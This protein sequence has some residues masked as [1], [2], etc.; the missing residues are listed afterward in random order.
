MN[1]TFWLNVLTPHLTPLVRSLA[2]LPNQAVTV[3][4]QGEPATVR[5]EIEWNLQDCTPAD[6]LQ[7]PTDEEVVRIL[8]QIQP[9]R[10][11]VHL[12][13]G[14]TNVPFNQRILPRLVERGALVGLITESADPRGILGAARRLKY[15]LDSRLMNRKTGFILAMGQLGVQWFI[16]AGYNIAT[17]Y[18]F[19]YVPER[20]Q[21][22]ME[23]RKGR[24]GSE[25]F[26]I[27][28]L[29]QIIPRKDG[30]T[31]IRALAGI[32]KANWQVSFVGNGPDL[33]RWKKVASDSGVA[34]RMC[35]QPAVDYRRVGELLAQA[36]ILLL[37]SRWDG[38]GAVVNEAL[39]C[40]VPVVCSDKC[41]AADLLREPWRGQI[42]KTGSAEDLR[43]VLN[44]WI[45]RGP[46]STETT[47]RIR[48]WSS[49]IEA[50]QV[51]LYLMR[52]VEHVQNGGLPPSP[53]WY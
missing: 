53:P 52:V 27:L 11:S 28:Y 16:S 45:E 7:C 21:L 33:K 40:G 46:R 43:R 13:N 2:R 8:G 23:G 50:P 20:P 19:M 1:W 37:P 10:L 47:A 49:A 35:F 39:M 29:G 22:A 32:S 48:K 12:L 30:I 3:V 44:E 5:K 42:F 14:I 25:A 17:V 38:W 31:A 26:S 18:P 15:S 36:D 4:A 51:A 9:E 41:G 6:L 34:S 24:D